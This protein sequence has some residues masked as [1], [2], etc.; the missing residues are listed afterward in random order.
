MGE[1]SSFSFSSLASTLRSMDEQQRTTSTGGHRRQVS[2][3]EPPVRSLNLS[4]PPPSAKSTAGFSDALKEEQDGWEI[5]PEQ[6][7]ASNEQQEAVEDDFVPLPSGAARSSSEQVE[8]ESAFE[9]VS[10]NEGNPTTILEQSSRSSDSPS[11][12]PTSTPPLSPATT[13]ATTVGGPSS[14]SLSVPPLGPSAVAEPTPSSSSPTPEAAAA[15]S[16]SPKPE[17]ATPKKPVSTKTPTAMQRF[18][19]MT[20]Q[21]D[22]PPKDKEEEVRFRF[23]FPPFLGL[24]SL[25]SFCIY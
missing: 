3:D 11:P 17:E 23:L 9:A 1:F 13:A 4:S 20:R 12:A 7:R 25:P 15:P 5:M 16:P 21:R 8:M 6:P 18:M 14:S 2:L 10:L 19:S 24:F 22:L